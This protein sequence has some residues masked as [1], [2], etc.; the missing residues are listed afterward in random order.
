ME[1]RGSGWPNIITIIYDINLRSYLPKHLRGSDEWCAAAV[2]GKKKKSE[3]LQKMDGFFFFGEAEFVLI[4]HGRHLFVIKRQFL[5]PQE[6]VAEMN[7]PG[8]GA[9]SDDD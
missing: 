4:P 2:Q 8:R 7:G 9:Q 1:K 3:S 6:A 5:R